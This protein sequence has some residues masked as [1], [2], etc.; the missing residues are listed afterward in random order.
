MRYDVYI[1]VVRRQRVKPT[2]RKYK[3]A[4]FVKAGTVL[5]HLK[6]TKVHKIWQPGETELTAKQAG[7]TVDTNDIPADLTLLY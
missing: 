2:L 7:K 1:Y 6:L 5:S 3:R 4:S